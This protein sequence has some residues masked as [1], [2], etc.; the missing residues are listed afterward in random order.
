MLA[1]PEV[2]NNC[3]KLRS[4]AAAPSGTPSSK[5]CGPEAPNNSPDSPLSSSADRSSFQ[6]TSN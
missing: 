2:D 6:A 5:I 4:A 3:A 1:I